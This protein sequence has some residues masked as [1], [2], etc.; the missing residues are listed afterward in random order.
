MKSDAATPQDYLDTLPPDRRAVVA[1][2]RDLVNAHLPT[3][4]REGM[5][6]G[7]LGWA[8]PLER[9][10][11][12]YNGQPLAYVGL[13]AQKNYYA[14][15]LMG[16]YMSPERQAALESAYAAAGKKLDMGK[17]CLRFKKLDD[18]VPGAVAEAVASLGVDDF[19][20]LYE[21]ERK[22]R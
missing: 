16:V 22:R 20:A 12:T 15:Y 19:I 4:Y 8:V 3:G 11:D 10:P 2:V 5:A 1:A 21:A 17:S 13:A 6:W 7:M 14:L 9:Y 18:L